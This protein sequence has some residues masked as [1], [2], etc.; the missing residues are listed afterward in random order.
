MVPI[1]FKEMFYRDFDMYIFSLGPHRTFR[2]E[3]L[4]ESFRRQEQDNIFVYGFYGTIY[5]NIFNIPQ[6]KAWNDIRRSIEYK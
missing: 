4:S 6:H 5:N 1:N 3:I 2:Y